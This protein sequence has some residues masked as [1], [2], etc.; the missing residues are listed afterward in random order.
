MHPIASTKTPSDATDRSALLRAIKKGALR[1]IQKLLAEREFPQ[2]ALEEAI[3]YACEYRF[4]RAL[5]AI[6]RADETL[7]VDATEFDDHERTPLHMASLRGA[8]DCCEAL[9]ELG[10]DPLKTDIYGNTAL[11]LGAFRGETATV[12]FLIDRSDPMALD[13]DGHTALE[14]AG[15]NGFEQTV[16]AIM[17]SL[18]ANEARKQCKNAAELARQND[19]RDAAELIDLAIFSI[20]ERDALQTA[21]RVPAESLCSKSKTI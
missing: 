3:F 1:P 12:Q 8:T 13:D 6:A 9:I 2:V 19:R 5:R 14:W 15:Y 11:I 17:E 7:N 4:A 10:A 21:I 18:P 16:F 20:D